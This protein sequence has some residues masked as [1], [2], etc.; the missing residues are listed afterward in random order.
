MLRS[1]SRLP[2]T[3]GAAT[4]GSAAAVSDGR[5]ELGDAPGLR[6][7]LGVPARRVRLAGRATRR[8]AF[9]LA[10]ARF[11]ALRLRMARMRLAERHLQRRAAGRAS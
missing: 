10:R 5:P 11:S 7:R 4:L 6:S 3:W 9:A 1:A 8:S 2:L